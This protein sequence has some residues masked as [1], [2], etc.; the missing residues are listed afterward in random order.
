MKQPDRRATARTLGRP[1]WRALK[2]G[3]GTPEIVCKSQLL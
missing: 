3:T 1:L 2:A